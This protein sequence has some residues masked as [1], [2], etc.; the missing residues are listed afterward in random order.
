MSLDKHHIQWQ[1]YAVSAQLLLMIFLLACPLPVIANIQAPEQSDAKTLVLKAND[2][3][4]RQDFAQTKQLLLEL[5]KYQDVI[6]PPGRLELNLAI[7]D[8]QSN[9]WED[10]K[11]ESQRASQ[12]A[13]NGSMTESD[14]LALQARCLVAERH[15]AKA[16]PLYE[17]AL[18]IAVNNLGQW[19]CDLA[20]LYE[21]L[22]SCYLAEKNFVEAS[23]LYKK[24][25][26]LDYL[27]YGPDSTQFGWSI[28]SLTSALRQPD[29][30]ELGTTL[31]K[32][33][34]WNFR[35]QNELRILEELKAKNELTPQLEANLRKQLYGLTNAYDDRDIAVNCLASE[36]PA[37]ILSSPPSRPQNFDNWYKERVGRERA[38]GLGFF[39]PHKELKGLIVTV[40]G[41]GLHNAAY[42]PFAERIIQS[43][44]GVIS[45][46]VRGFGSYR[47][48]EVYEHVDFD[49][50]IQDLQRILTALRHDYPGVPMFLLG[51]SMGGAIALRV[52]AL[53]PDLVDGLVSSVP[54]G[55]RFQARSTTLEVAVRLLKNSHKQF[56]F[57]SKVVSQATKDPELRSTWGDDPRARMKFS[58]IDLIVFQKFMND[59][60]KFAE[61]IK[62][63]PVI[64]FQG[65]SD[66]LVKP[67]GTLA[68]YH[69][70][71]V[72]DKDLIFVGHAEH[73][74]FEEGQFDQDIVDGLAS[75][76]DRHTSK[77]NK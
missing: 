15:S 7:C 55:A 18:V 49:A 23:K 24:V 72:K 61:Q 42:Q 8:S 46:D 73:L 6:A 56:D 28:L 67:L 77:Q 47:N 33:V 14:A 26:E 50:I 54:S 44:F 51:E 76:L 66:E 36:I 40:H 5:K 27:K 16:K 53:S 60:L 21:G 31:Y 10:A 11:N 41:L 39:N 4:W 2:T 12:L 59:N 65:Y 38:P 43:G 48:D 19:N 22:A 63:T 32:K 57:G 45:F 71:P 70:M 35:R 37:N 29:E 74:I 25:A 52:T 20:A 13:E 17:R 64:I 75:W 62:T 9:N 30:K 1:R 68:L 69:A 34:F 3:F 58:P